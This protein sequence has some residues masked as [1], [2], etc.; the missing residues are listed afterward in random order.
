[1]N[2][3]IRTFHAGTDALRAVLRPSKKHPRPL[4]WVDRRPFAPL[5]SIR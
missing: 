2:R 5:W 4:G 3:Q 1:M